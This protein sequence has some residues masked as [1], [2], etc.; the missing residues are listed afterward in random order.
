MEYYIRNVDEYSEDPRQGNEFAPAWRF[1]MVVSGSSDSGKTTMLMNL[2][3]GNKGIKEDG[4]RYV[5]CNDVVLI[6]KH[7]NEPK[8]QIVKDFYDGLAE[9][10]EDVSFQ[11]ISPDN[12]PD[13]EEFD[14]NRYT[15]VVFEDLMN[16]PK[17]IQ[18][19]IADYF[20][21]GRHSNIS[22]I[23]VNQR[24]FAIPKTVRENINYISLHRGAGSLSD[25]KRIIS[26]YTEHSDTLAPVIDDLTL[27]KEFIV[28]DLRRSRDDPLSIRVRWD[29]SL[30]SILDQSQ[31]E[32]RSILD[33][34]SSVNVLS[35]TNLR[36]N[37]FSSYGR[38]AIAEA[39]KNGLLIEYA[40]NFPSPKERKV[41]LAEGIIAKNKDIWTRYV[42]REAYGISGK[43]L[44]PEWI[45][46]Q[47]LVKGKNVRSVS[48]SKKIISE[49]MSSTSLPDKKFIEG[50]E[51]LLWLFSNGHISRKTLCDGI[52]GFPD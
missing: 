29:T 20:S 9:E 2:L 23:Y 14:P 1:G 27:K 43:D 52:K 8:W 50:C 32:P 24:F 35:M 49:L 12:I 51:A 21:S 34:S 36:S 39:K 7:P 5:L 17:K 40:K 4:E 18:E 31:I 41:L 45:K 6:A 46:F 38:E 37:I 10:G 33:Q 30:R 26:Q 3:M 28:F 16:M 22:P 25:I 11:V 13:L 42:F 48:S 19:Q 15:V 47:E 44:G